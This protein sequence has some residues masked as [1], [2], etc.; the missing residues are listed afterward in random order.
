MK[1]LITGASG[2]LGSYLTEMFLEAGHE[3][4]ALVRKTS[5]TASLER[6]GVEIAQGD[7]TNRE[8]LERAVQGMEIVIHAAATM[9]GPAAEFVAASEQGTRSLLE[10]AE[11]AG[12]RRF[13]QISSISVLSMAKPPRGESINEDTPYESNPVFLG[14]YNKSKMAAERAALEYAE[15]GAMN[16]IVL[17]PGILYGPR[18]NWVISRLGYALGKNL[19]AVVGMGGNH[20][21]VC[22]VRNCARAALAA[23]ENQ[24]VQNEAFN[25]LDDEPFTQVEY[26]KRLRTEARPNLNILRVPYPLARAL[27]WFSGLAMKMLGRGNPIATAYLVAC[28]RRLRY[29]NEKAKRFL[30]WK[31][32]TDKDK[33][34]AETMRNHAERERLSRAADIRLLG[35][36]PLDREPLTACLVGCG[37]IARAHLEFLEHMKNARVLAICDSNREAAHA[38]ADEFKILHTY[39]N[40][41]R[42]LEVERPQVVHILTP[43]QSHLE[44]V[45][46]IATRG[47]HILC[48]KPMAM[49]ANDARRM[50]EIA[51]ENGVQLCMDHNHLF[52]PV[53]VRARA[54]IES[55]AL[56]DIIW[57][58]SYYG[59]DLGN[60]RNS[61]YMLPGGGD[62]WTFKIPGGLYLNLGPHPFSTALDVLGDIEEIIVRAD[63]S[64]VVPHQP[65]DELRVFLKT[66]RGSGMVNISLAASPRF[67]YMKIVGTRARLTVD[68]LNKW[69]IREGVAR[70]IPKPISRA[71]TNL[72]YGCTILSGTFSGMVNVRRHGQGSDEEVDAL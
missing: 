42:M 64:R 7:L 29:S 41:E 18:G 59:F 30:G 33:L 11:N 31:P 62:H 36:A 20:L 22:H 24:D 45:K 35:K 17:R 15:K 63:P 48:E 68:F 49:N 32:E 3:V 52:D 19:V 16:V 43:P 14:V 9:S 25:I 58:E 50:V 55:G 28:V 46:T 51:A 47:C 5:K 57:V 72:R 2:F 26:L 40:V 38:L 61:R 70:G 10:V 37:M 71:M 56:G 66:S 34:L 60:N 21:P 4:R 12:V 39:D 27:G 44:L 65:T 53:M 69:M 23:V 8:S 6:L 54:L 67:Q 13:V 1:V